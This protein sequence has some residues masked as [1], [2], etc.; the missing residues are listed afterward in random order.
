MDVNIYILEDDNNYRKKIMEF[1]LSY[2]S[3]FITINFPQPHNHL[4]F[5]NY[6]QKKLIEDTDIFFLD[7]DLKT[8]FSGIDIAK[9]IRTINSKATI[10][11]LTTA[12]DQA[13]NI[14]NENIYPT[15]Y[16]KKEID[17]DDETLKNILQ[18]LH[19]FEKKTLSLNK[20]NDV[21]V[22]QTRSETLFFKLSQILFIES[23]SG[24][25]GHVLIRTM[26]KQYLI[27]MKINTVKKQFP[28][29]N[30]LT[31]LQ[32]FIINLDNIVGY[33]KS[34]TTLIFQNDVI[35]STGVKVFNKVVN[36]IKE[37][38]SSDC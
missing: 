15:R 26:D 14:I 28:Q 4:E 24:H 6:F 8:N 19:D 37:R 17:N 7:I 25:K 10:I 2:K 34:S 38:D 22:F 32:S 16:L 9:Q 23:V 21:V 27:K 29:K 20:H 33:N 1:I 13:I 3:N 36:A 11:F 31:N 30:M 12:A 35:L 5:M 18:I